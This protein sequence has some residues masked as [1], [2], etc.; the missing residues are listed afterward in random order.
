VVVKAGL[1]LGKRTAGNSL[2]GRRRHF[3]VRFSCCTL[4]YSTLLDW[5]HHQRQADCI[6]FWKERILSLLV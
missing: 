2:Q 4:F 1:T 5:R 3:D 6:E